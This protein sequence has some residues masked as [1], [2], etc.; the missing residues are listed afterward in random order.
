MDK[1]YKVTTEGD[2]EGRSTRTIAYATGNKSD[3]MSFYDDRKMYEIRLEE[4]D[5]VHITPNSTA[6]KVAMIKRKKELEAELELLK[7]KLK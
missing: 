5:I 6:E 7:K 2:C 1:I 4:L 3:I